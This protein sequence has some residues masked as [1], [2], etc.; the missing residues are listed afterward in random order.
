MD[1]RRLR[2]GAAADWLVALGFLLATVL[3]AALLVR[4]MRTVR[5]VPPAT[6]APPGPPAG[7]PDHAVS[8][9]A[10]LLLDGKQL[11]VGD[12]LE[13]VRFQIGDAAEAAA[14]ERGRLGDRVT[15]TYNHA[16]TKFV[17]VF[18]PFERNGPLTVAAI[19]LR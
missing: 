13:Q 17:L 18:E 11:R 6:V 5:T 19:Y 4:E 14:V 7:L 8:V 16:G 2:L 1:V 15:H 12:T 10:L 3:V 9:P